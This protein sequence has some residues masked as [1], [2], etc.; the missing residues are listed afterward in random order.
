MGDR[1][2]RHEMAWNSWESKF[3]QKLYEHIGTDI[4]MVY[5]SAFRDYAHGLYE[6]RYDPQKAFDLYII[7]GLPKSDNVM[8][9]Y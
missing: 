6:R 4:D 9:R 1:V 5:N 2:E 3:K 7:H 8:S